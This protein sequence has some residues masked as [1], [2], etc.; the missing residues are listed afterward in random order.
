MAKKQPEKARRWF[1]RWTAAG[2]GSVR[3]RPHRRGRGRGALHIG[4]GRLVEP[5]RHWPHDHSNEPSR[6]K[7]DAEHLDDRLSC[8]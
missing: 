8:F 7:L 3:G 4:L 6:P 1:P 5:Q 2:G